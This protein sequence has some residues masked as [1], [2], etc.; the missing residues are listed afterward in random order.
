MLGSSAELGATEAMIRE[1][2]RNN[3]AWNHRYFLVF[4]AEE[5][6]AGGRGWGT[7]VDEEIVDREV[8]Y[9]KA[10]ISMAPQNQSPWNYLRGVLRRAGRKLSEEEDFAAGFVEVGDLLGEGTVRSSFAVDWLSECWAEQGEL[11]RAR[12]GLQALARKW[13]PVRKGY[14]EYRAR[15][16]EEGSG[17]MGEVRG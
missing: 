2:V 7:V 8:E 15:L 5:L 11:E 3:S 16:L 12:E 13:D 4:G 9:A 1:D 17:G 10:K 14:W 6:R